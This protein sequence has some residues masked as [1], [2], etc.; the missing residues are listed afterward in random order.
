VEEQGQD[1]DVFEHVDGRSLVSAVGDNTDWN[2]A[3]R[4]L[5]DLQHE[6]KLALEQETLPH[7][8]SIENLWLT[9]GGNL[10]LL[11]F[12]APL[13]DDDISDASTP[14][15][16]YLMVAQKPPVLSNSPTE[17]V[18]QLLA[19]VAQ[20]LKRALRKRSH[21]DLPPPLFVTRMLDRL[22]GCEDLTSKLDMLKIVVTKIQI[23]D[24]RQRLLMS[25][26][27]YS[28]P[29]LLTLANFGSEVINLLYVRNNPSVRELTV[30]TNIAMQN[31]QSNNALYSDAKVV[32][33]NNLT[34]PSDNPTLK[35]SNERFIKGA[36]YLDPK[37]GDD[38]NRE[39]EAPKATQKE[40]EAALERIKASAAYKQW[41]DYPSIKWLNGPLGPATV[42]PLALLFIVAVPALLAGLLFRGGLVI[43]GF[44]TVIVEMNGYPAGRLRILI[45]NA[46]QTSCVFAV[47]WLW[48]QASIDRLNF[49]TI[50]ALVVLYGLGVISNLFGLRSL[51]DRIVGSAVV[52]KE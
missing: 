29:I 52:S 31:A 27:C 6:L 3:R 5:A 11:D 38:L 2:S 14:N 15:Q 23:S 22:A 24:R 30:V 42:G 45:R 28:I 37:F 46:I 1:W 17:R 18:D 25:A 13:S 41:D 4:W 36:S 40:V 12:P 21:R 19:N 20:L 44:R 7:S 51:A 33:V 48:Y 32:L 49:P 8:L 9:D 43:H 39:L 16:N 50:G 35:Q 26:A 10:K 34:T 47:C